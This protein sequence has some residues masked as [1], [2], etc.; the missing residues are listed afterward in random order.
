MRLPNHG[1]QIEIK[2]TTYKPGEGQRE[3]KGLKGLFIKL[4]VNKKGKEEG[5]GNKVNINISTVE[6]KMK[7]I[8]S[9]KHDPIKFGQER[10]AS[11]L[12]ARAVRETSLQSQSSAKKTVSQEHKHSRHGSFTSVVNKIPYKIH[13][14]FKIGEANDDPFE[15]LRHLKAKYRSPLT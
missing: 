8:M 3:S 7:D 12:K 11:L 5:K 6:Q 4:G 15:S 10:R 14:F 1:T 2:E 9:R 13:Q